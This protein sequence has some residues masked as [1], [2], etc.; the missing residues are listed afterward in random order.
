MR[1]FLNICIFT[2]LVVSAIGAPAA[3]QCSDVLVDS[4]VITATVEKNKYVTGRGLY[5]YLDMLHPDLKKRLPQLG[6]ADVLM[7]LGTGKANALIEYLKSF[8]DVSLAPHTIG[9]AYKLDRWFSPP[10][11]NGK[12]QI[13]E[14]AFESHDVAS[15]KKVDVMLDVFGVVSYTHDMHGTLQ[16]VFDLLK[17]GG[18]FYLHMTYY[19]LSIHRDGKSQS[20]TDFLKSIDGLEVDGTYGILKITKLKDVIEIPKMKLIR[21]SEEMPPFRAFQIPDAGDHNE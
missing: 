7:D 19:S 3:E 5:D 16:R 4:W 9:I 6:P 8:A 1:Q 15:W 14:G 21:Y 12:L 13:I 20:L 18:E 10:K 2:L 17:P 11:F